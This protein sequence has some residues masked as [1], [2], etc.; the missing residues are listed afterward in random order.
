LKILIPSKDTNPYLTEI[1][2]ELKKRIS[3]EQSMETF[4]KPNKSQKLINGLNTERFEDSV[5]SK[6]LNAAL[7]HINV[8]FVFSSGILYFY[9][10]L[11]FGT[12][13]LFKDYEKFESYLKNTNYNYLFAVAVSTKSAVSVDA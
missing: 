2:F 10:Q 9:D 5:A 4:F 3:V 6:Y 13:K 11:S 12:L 8:E 1:V 7:K